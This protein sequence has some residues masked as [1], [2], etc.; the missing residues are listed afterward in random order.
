MSTKNGLL[1]IITLIINCFVVVQAQE[2]PAD[3]DHDDTDF[4]LSGAHL[5]VECAVCH[6]RDVYKGIPVTCEECHTTSSLI[7]KSKKPATHFESV[8]TC[9]NCHTVETWAGA[10]IDH[11]SVVGTCIDCHNNINS[12]GRPSDHVQSVDECHECHTTRRWK[13]SGFDHTV[14]TGNCYSCHNGTTATGKSEK[15]RLSNNQCADCHQVQ[16]WK[17]KTFN[18]KDI[19]SACLGC[20]KDI[21][22]QKP[23]PQDNKC[24]R[25]HSPNKKWQ[26]VRF[27]HEKTTEFCVNC[28]KGI[29]P[30]SHFIIESEASLRCDECHNSVA[31]WLSNVRFE[32]EVADFHEHRPSTQCTACHLSNSR[33]VLF[34]LVQFKPVCAACHASSY[35]A[36][37]HQK[38]P[39]VGYRLEELAHCTIACHSYTDSTLTVR[40]NRRNTN[41]HYHST[42]RGKGITPP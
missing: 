3:F 36:S 29:K 20:H 12:T 16:N 10:R 18:H 21:L 19:G 22:P 9:D 42:T 30:T 38:Y 39:G 4:L 5:K 6:V 7:A 17:S 13:Q 25:C 27:A 1:L 35:R 28:H 31:S 11:E 32:H 8:D 14:I 15:H 40:D 23:H 37:S 34:R 26:Q 2:I 33:N 24:I 41:A